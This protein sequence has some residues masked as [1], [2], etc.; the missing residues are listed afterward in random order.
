MGMMNHAQMNH[1]PGMH[2]GSMHGSMQKGGMQHGSDSHGSAK[3]K[4]DSS[5][6]SLAFHGVN[7]KMHDG[8]DITFTGNADADF[9]RGMIPHHQGAVDMA[10]KALTQAEHEELRSLAQTI[11]DAQTAEIAQLE[12]WEAEWFAS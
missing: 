6:S 4:G 9:V 7:Q 1:G 11:I 8:M 3:P 12:E 2:H 5:P 10:E